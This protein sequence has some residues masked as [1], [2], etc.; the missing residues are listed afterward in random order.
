MQ[1]SLLFSISHPNTGINYRL[2]FTS[3]VSLTQDENYWSK[4]GIVLCFGSLLTT[5]AGV[6]SS[7]GRDYKGLVWTGDPFEAKHLI[8]SYCTYDGLCMSTYSVL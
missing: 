2:A 1:R 4:N 6:L 3:S 8:I 5:L 7:F